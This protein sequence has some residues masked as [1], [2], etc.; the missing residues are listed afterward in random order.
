MTMWGK[1]W[2]QPTWVG[3]GKTSLRR[4]Y[5]GQDL[6]LKS[7]AQP[8]GRLGGQVEERASPS[9]GGSRD[10]PGDGPQ[11][12][13]SGLPGLPG[14][15]RLLPGHT[16]LGLGFI[17][18]NFLTSPATGKNPRLAQSL[19]EPLWAGAHGLSHPAG[20]TFRAHG[21]DPAFQ[22]P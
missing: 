9:T 5:L 22:V 21:L 19:N 4:W 7:A 1:A 12:A 2:W 10:V 17:R 11:S 13:L 14:R 18:H 6:R 16:V 20:G 15:A 3:A 8:R